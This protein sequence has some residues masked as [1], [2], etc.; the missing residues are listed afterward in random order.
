[1]TQ[2]RQQSKP[3]EDTGTAR[4]VAGQV[5]DVLALSICRS[6]RHSRLGASFQCVPPTDGGRVGRVRAD[7]LEEEV[8]LVE[9]ELVRHPAAG[10]IAMG[11]LWDVMSGMHPSVHLLSPEID[12]E[13]VCYRVGVRVAAAEPLGLLREQTLHKVFNDIAERA[14]RLKALLPSTQK[15]QLPSSLGKLADRLVALGSQRP[16]TPAEEGF[17]RNAA[18]LLGAGPI[19]L[20]GGEDVERTLA[21]ELLAHELKPTSVPLVGLSESHPL[22]TLPQLAAEVWRRGALLSAPVANLVPQNSA[23]E[24]RRVVRSVLRSLSTRGVPAVFHGSEDDMS[25]MFGVAGAGQNP[26]QPVVLQPP[27]FSTERLLGHAVQEAGREAGLGQAPVDAI[28]KMAGTAVADWPADVVRSRLQPLATALV[29]GF[30]L[31]AAPGEQVVRQCLERVL[32]QERCLGGLKDQAERVRGQRVQDRLLGVL[33]DAAVMAEHKER[34]IGQER[35]IEELHGRLVS[36]LL[37][38][39]RHRPLVVLLEGPPGVGKSASVEFLARSFSMPL[40]YVDAAAIGSYHQAHSM[41]LGSGRGIV[42]SY[43]PGLLEEACRTDTGAVIEV[44]DL[45]HIPDETRRAVAD[46]FLQ[47]MERGMVTSGTGTPLHG[48]NLVL[49]FTCNLPG[50]GDRK[51]RSSL[52]FAAAGGRNDKEVGKEVSARLQGL[53]T[54][55][56]LSRTGAPVL[57]DPLEPETWKQIVSRLLADA[58]TRALGPDSAASVS[59]APGA[60]RWIMALAERNGGSSDARTLSSL[61]ADQV[62][63]AVL[64]SRCKPFSG[65]PAA[66][67]VSAGRGGI[68]IQRRKS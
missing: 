53:F 37:C 21:L 31:G 1:M 44:A 15:R 40:L 30:R 34:V 9:V 66:C 20:C 51:A 47:L 65:D 18:L 23:Y 45:D 5:L 19:A 56:F 28:V 10:R 25:E 7:L 14:E 55:A 67:I 16:A 22:E 61:V 27:M 63:R 52:G 68:R 11:A 2:Q 17:G 3:A 38:R 33:S 57:F 39:S 50:D 29:M 59:V 6:H 58:I 32:T 46:L 54:T 64:A 62:A 26:L 49:C 24:M 4:A 48:S 35:A 43:Q 41:L 12:G 42:N 60:V 36:Q 13:D 8:L